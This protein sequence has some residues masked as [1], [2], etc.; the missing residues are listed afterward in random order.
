MLKVLD[1]L[2]LGASD[3]SSVVSVCWR[4]LMVLVLVPVIWDLLCLYAEGSWWSW[5]RFLMVLVLV[6]VIWDLLCLYAEGSWWSWSWCQWSGICCVCMLKVLDG[7][8]L[9][10]G[11]SD[12][13]SV[14]FVCWRFLMVLVLVLKVHLFHHQRH[15]LWC[16][17]QWKEKLLQAWNFVITALCRQPTT[18]KYMYTLHRLVVYLTLNVG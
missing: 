13:R 17:I 1:G 8:G 18:C 2:G 4:F 12:L 9:G 16:R 7:L 10:L 11:A 15:L 3:L 5:W 6:P 14:V